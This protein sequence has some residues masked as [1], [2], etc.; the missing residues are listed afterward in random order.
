MKKTLI[1]AGA[2]LAIYAG[3]SHAQTIPE[4]L[5]TDLQADFGFQDFQAAGVVGSLARETGNFRYLQEINPIVE[6]SRGG[7]GY[8]QW[9]GPRRDAFEAWAGEGA[10]L[11][12]YEVNYGYLAHE[13]R[14]DYSRVVERVRETA[15]VEEAAEVFTRDFLGPHPDH[16]A[17]DERVAYAKAYVGGDFTGAGC[18]EHHEVQVDGRLM[19]V[20]MC[21]PT[22]GIDIDTTVRMVAAF[23]TDPGQLAFAGVEAP[24]EEVVFA[25]RTDL[26]YATPEPAA[27]PPIL[28]ADRPLETN[29]LDFAA[30]GGLA[31]MTNVETLS[32]QSTPDVE[33]PDAHMT[34]LVRESVRGE[35]ELEDD[36]PGLG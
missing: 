21:D 14:G 26:A 32:F 6:G 19:V 24:R 30:A 36:L 5:M 9:T 3:A 35:P 10:D 28:L 15:S 29:P 2:S 11:T 12:T 13:L 23:P 20:A 33:T 31:A 27:D 8:P 7:I 18:Q 1:A 22:N 34:L 17:M 25:A 16:V 4:Q